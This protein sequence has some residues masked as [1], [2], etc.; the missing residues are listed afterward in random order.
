[1]RQYIASAL[2]DKNGQ[3][4][5]TGKDFKYLCQ[6]LRLSVGDVIQVRLP[7]QELVDMQVFKLQSKQIILVK[8]ICDCSDNSVETGVNASSLNEIKLPEIW[9]FQFLPKMQK[10]DLIIRQSTECGVTKIIPV[11]SDF[12]SKDFS[13]KK[14]DFERITR[15]QRIVKE[16]RQ[17][18]GSAINTQIENPM[19]LGDAISLWQENFKNNCGFVLYE[20]NVAKKNIFSVLKENF[21]KIDRI[22]IVVGGEGGISENE[23]LLLEKEGFNLV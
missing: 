1:M 8:E 9:L 2:P 3:L 16:A 7:N 22:G 12:S 10:M 13:Y 14:D 11:I 21:N 17:Q 5:I 6:V 15:W 19:L 20:A 23:I 18:S 4:S